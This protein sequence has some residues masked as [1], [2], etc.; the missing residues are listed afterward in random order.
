MPNLACPNND[1]DLHV[2]G[3]RKDCPDCAKRRPAIKY[4]IFIQREAEQA[5][6][7]LTNLTHEEAS[8]ALSTKRPTSTVVEGRKVKMT[9]PRPRTRL[10]ALVQQERGK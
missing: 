3:S 7:L 6:Q 8:T 10:A 1:L 4:A 9:R 2:E 5:E